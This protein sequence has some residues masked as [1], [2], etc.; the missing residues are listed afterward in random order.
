VVAGGTA[1]YSFNL[2][3]TVYAGTITFACS[4]LP[5]GAN[6]SFSPSTVTAN[7]CSTG[8][9]VALSITTAQGTV[10]AGGFG[11]FGNGRWQ[12]VAMFPA[13]GLALLIG[14]RRRKAGTRWAQIAMSL[15]LL[16]GLSS[17]MA[18]NS[19]VVT[20]T[21][22]TPKGTSTVTVTATGSA[23]TI[24]SFTVPLTVN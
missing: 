23:G 7:G 16:V 3:Q 12:L 20:G 1:L 9:T 5:S 4:G 8:N 19:T 18:C 15:A 2:T 24:S 6:C 17:L 14:L 22:A 11:G 10:T 13:I 21:G